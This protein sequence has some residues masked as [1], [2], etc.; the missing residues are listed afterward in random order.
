[1]QG[2]AP[3]SSRFNILVYTMGDFPLLC[4][5]LFI[6]CVFVLYDILVRLSSFIGWRD[7]YF[8]L[9]TILG[10]WIN[11]V[12]RNSRWRTENDFT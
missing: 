3:P 12:Q 6:A 2:H 10:V 5:P 7:F 8:F 9:L 1:M 4:S 11:L